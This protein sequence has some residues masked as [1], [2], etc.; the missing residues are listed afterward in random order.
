MTKEQFL[1]L[2]EKHS[3]GTASKKEIKLVESFYD[4]FQN[5]ETSSGWDLS[6]EEEIRLRMLRVITKATQPEKSIHST[7]LFMGIAA[8][9]LIL[10]GAI[11][12][13]LLMPEETT[14][15]EWVTSTTT[16]TQRKVVTLPD[17][18]TV[19]LNMGSELRFPE[20]FSE[21]DRSVILH[22]EGFFEVVR[23]ESRPFI[24]RT[25]ELTTT[26][27][28]TSFN[29]RAYKDENQD[30][31]VMTGKV[32]VE[33]QDLKVTLD[34]GEQAY[35]DVNMKHLVKNVVDPTM[36]AGW[37]ASELRFDLVEFQD[38]ITRLE[39][40]YR[41]DFELKDQGKAP[42]PVRANY[43]N[44]SISYVLDGL[45]NIVAFDYEILNN[46]SIKLTSYGCKN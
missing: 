14:P 42:C 19:M 16:L 13:M 10:V 46:Q 17:G 25:E 12:F 15:V 6:G 22:G 32:S 39:R 36:F 27:L 20:T 24:V 5:K 8:S 28:G 34:P 30:I 7:R 43:E 26:V 29:V 38:I 31:T 21:S 44:R 33:S 18:S 37:T 11:G 40:W 41:I 23:D 45:Q 4:Q 3:K 9:V 1:E 35:F 2:A